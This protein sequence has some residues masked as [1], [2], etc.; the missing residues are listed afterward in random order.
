MIQLS[1]RHVGSKYSKLKE[2]EDMQIDSDA[3][4]PETRKKRAWKDSWRLKTPVV[5]NNWRKM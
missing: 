1:K 5:R 4:E 2:E 3:S